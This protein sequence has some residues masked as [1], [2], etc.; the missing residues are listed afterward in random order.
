MTLMKTI[1]IAA[2]IG[3]DLRTRVF[4][5]RDIEKLIRVGVPV[6]L[7]FAGVTFVSRSVADEIFNLLEDY[8]FVSLKGME[9]NVKSMFD[10]VKRGRISPRCYKDVT[11]PSVKLSTMEEVRNFFLAM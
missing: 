3:T 1:E 2:A 4:F 7:D 8:P 9:G 10:V 5:R 11:V 6:E